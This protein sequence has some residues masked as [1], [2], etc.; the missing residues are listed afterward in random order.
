MDRNGNELHSDNEIENEV[1]DFFRHFYAESE[2]SRFIMEGLNWYPLQNVWAESLEAPFCE[3]EI[4]KAISSLGNLKSLGPN[5]M[6]VEFYKKTWNILKTNL[7]RVFRE[8]FENVIVNKCTNETYVC[9]IPKKKP[10]NKVG[11]FRP[12]SLVTSLYK[13]IA[14][15]LAGRLKKVLH[16]I[17]DDA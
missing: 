17:I 1:V 8:F 2:G 7:V 4:W 13:I 10:A 11:E 14:K 12:I 6:S 5:G 9:L 15:V 16:L 3:K